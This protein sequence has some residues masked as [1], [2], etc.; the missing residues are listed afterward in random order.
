M[1][2]MWPGSLLSKGIIACDWRLG[3]PKINL[4]EDTQESRIFERKSFSESIGMCSSTS[5]EK[6]ASKF[7]N[8]GLSTKLWQITDGL[9]FQRLELSDA[10][11]VNSSQ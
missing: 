3:I 1:Q 8:R 5:N 10:S 11:S 2:L 9:F 4:L 6:A 7:R